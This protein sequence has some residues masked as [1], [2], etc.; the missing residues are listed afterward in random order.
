M[1]ATSEPW[2]A[3]LSSA[4]FGFATM[5]WSVLTAS[6]R[7]TV[8]PDRLMGRISSVNRFL[9]WGSPP[10]GSLLGCALAGSFGLRV[11]FVV[12]GLAVVVSGL[13][14]GRTLLGVSGCPR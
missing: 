7:Q 14:A 5:T 6:A 2:L 4:A 13:V 1:G 12:G 10:L 9:S 11:P 8:V 3:G